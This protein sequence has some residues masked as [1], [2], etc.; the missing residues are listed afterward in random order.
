MAKLEKT[1]IG[2]L[3]QLI[4]KIEE[5]ILNGSKSATLKDVPNTLL[6][7][8]IR[9]ITHKPM[10]KIYAILSK[11]YTEDKY[12]IIEK[13][14]KQINFSTYSFSEEIEKIIGLDNK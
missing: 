11:K 5:G 10:Q 8:D 3:E 7:K 2:D 13:L 9:D 12:T 14:D 1:F 6:K 4:K